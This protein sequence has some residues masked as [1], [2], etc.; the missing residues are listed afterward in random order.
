MC[1]TP[2]LHKGILEDV[3]YLCTA[4]THG[5]SGLAHLAMGQRI[6]AGEC[7]VFAVGGSCDQE[8]KMIPGFSA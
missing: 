5:E 4:S 7:G 1:I 3:L 8:G 2:D 6:K